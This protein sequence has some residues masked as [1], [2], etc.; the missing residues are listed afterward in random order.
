VIPLIRYET[1][2]LL[3]SQRWVPPFLVY[4]LLVAIATSPGQPLAAGLNW[5]A[6]MLVPAAAWLTRSMLTVEPGAARACVAAASGPRRAHLAAL[7]AALIGGIVFSLGGAAYE[8]VRCMKPHHAHGVGAALA[9][10]GPPLAAGLFAAM[11]CILVGSAVGTL[12]NPPLV[13]RPG[14]GILG[15]CAVV[16]V[17][18]VSNLSPAAAALRGIGATQ[19]PTAWLP[20]L[21]VAAAV[22]LTAAAWTLSTLVAARR[23]G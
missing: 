7:I 2:L 15:T 14:V 20:G 16:V 13:R 18:L 23:G 10:I 19:Q 21:P 6:A 12:C 3:R 22:I 17:A 8:V 1:A 5:S 11:V 9:A 4:A